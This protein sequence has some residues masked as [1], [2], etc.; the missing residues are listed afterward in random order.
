[1]N[2]W[3]KRHI[4]LTREERLLIAGILAIAL[5]GMTARLLRTPAVP[6]QPPPPTRNTR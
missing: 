3:I 5:V 6:D 4:S 1:M 2:S